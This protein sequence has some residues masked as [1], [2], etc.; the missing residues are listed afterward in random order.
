MHK[1]DRTF[2]AA[3]SFLSLPILLGLCAATASAQA[4]ADIGLGFGSHLASASSNGL[5]NANSPN[6]YGSC[7]PNTGDTFC[8]TL[9]KLNGLFMRLG[10][11][12]MFTDHFGGGFNFDFQ[13]TRSDYGPLQYRQSF[14]DVNG[15]YAPI[16]NKRWVPQL[17]GGIGGAR[18]GFAVSQSSCVGTAVCNSQ[19]LP[20]GTATHFQVHGGVAVQYFV[21]EHIFI[22]PEFDYHYIPNFTDQFG[23]NSVP[24]F[25]ITVG[26]GSS[27]Q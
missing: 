1:R 9:P 2:K 21:S 10:G 14:M 4:A 3:V 24:G 20:A 12:I 7:A 13:P 26:Y 11:D 5:D 18:T 23:R 15:I 19:V 16:N 22:K 6:A 27:R 8:Q 25:M 17:I